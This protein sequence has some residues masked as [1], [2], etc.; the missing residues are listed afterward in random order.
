MQRT[1]TNNNEQQ[2]ITTNDKASL[3][4]A[5]NKQQSKHGIQQMPKHH[6]EC[7]RYNIARSNSKSYQITTYHNIE[8][9]MEA[10]LGVF[11]AE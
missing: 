10:K 2:R 9:Q 6:N 11:M 8:R 7:Q 5:M 3:L 4:I 1:T